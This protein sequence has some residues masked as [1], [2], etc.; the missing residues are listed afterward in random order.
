MEILLS[1]IYNILIF[2]NSNLNLQADEGKVKRGNSRA[3]LVKM[4]VVRMSRY[5]TETLHAFL[6]GKR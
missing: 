2:D 4:V 1:R 5:Q 6:D 3:V